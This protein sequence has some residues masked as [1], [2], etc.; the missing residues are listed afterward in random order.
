MRRLL[1]G[2]SILT[3]V[4]AADHPVRTQGQAQVQDPPIPHATG[5]SIAPSFEGWYKN[6]DG[7]V[8]TTSPWRLVDYWGWTR[9]PRLEDYE[10]S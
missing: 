3:L 7:K 2:V 9:T 10:L 6:A 1:F 5:Q 8:L 4:I